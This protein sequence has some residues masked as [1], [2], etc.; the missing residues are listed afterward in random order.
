MTKAELIQM[1]IFGVRRTLAQIAVY[2]PGC[3]AAI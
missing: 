1:L 2:G 3:G